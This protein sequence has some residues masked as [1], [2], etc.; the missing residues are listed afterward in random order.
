MPYVE[1]ALLT[2]RIHSQGRLPNVYTQHPD[3]MKNRRPRPS[4]MY[5]TQIKSEGDEN[6]DAWH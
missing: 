2:G 4:G 3:N 5:I 1:T 6:L